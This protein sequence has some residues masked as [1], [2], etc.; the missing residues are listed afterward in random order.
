MIVTIA[1]AVIFALVAFTFFM[2]DRFVQRRNAVVLDSAARSNAIV[3]SL[4]PTEIQNRLMADKDAQVLP[5]VKDRKWSKFGAAGHRAA[6]TDHDR[7][8]FQIDEVRGAPIAD[9]FPDTTG[10]LE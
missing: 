8:G 7:P 10:M 5:V 3:S 6:N 4:F 9:F 2:Y 1:V